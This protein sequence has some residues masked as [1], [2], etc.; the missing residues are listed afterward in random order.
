MRIELRPSGSYDAQHIMT[1][2]IT[3]D[4]GHHDGRGNN[5]E[6]MPGPRERMVESTSR[7]LA[8]RGYEA[9]SFADVIAASGAPRGSIYHH[10][11]GGKDELVAEAIRVQGDRALALLGQMAGRPAVEIV[12]GFLAVWRSILTATDMRVGCSL[13]AV[14]VSGAHA[15]LR[16]AAGAAFELWRAELAYLLERGGVQAA[17]APALA[18]TLLASAE[19][20]VVLCRATRTFEPLEAVEL[21]LTSLVAGL[22]A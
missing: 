2:I 6:P 21:Q 3:S 17:D 19:G 16:D 1:L 15:E 18:M 11:P 14:T 22:T 9:T 4:E 5:V 20:A 7:L 10:F 13:V 8:E 12:T